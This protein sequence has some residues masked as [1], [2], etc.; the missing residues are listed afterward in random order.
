MNEIPRKPAVFRADDP[1]LETIVPDAAPFTD[2]ALA[3]TPPEESDALI[4]AAPRPPARRM[5]WGALFWSALS[6]LVLI[7]LGV[8]ITS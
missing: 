3:P 8:A 4:A 2:A 1:R 6:G 7:G 5:R